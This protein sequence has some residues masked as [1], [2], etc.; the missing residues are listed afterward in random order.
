MKQELLLLE[1]NV[2]VPPP[3]EKD[4]WSD[5]EA[6]PPRPRLQR[7]AVRPRHTTHDD[8]RDAH[9]RTKDPDQEPDQDQAN[10]RDARPR[11]AA[12]HDRHRPRF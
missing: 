3:T 6:P 10:A 4:D 11:R 12:V 9:K 1:D 5:H 7:D 8:A 2:L